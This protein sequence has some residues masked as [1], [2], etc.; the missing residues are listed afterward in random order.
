MTN[1]HI[2]GWGM[3]VPEKVLTNND[4]SKVVDTNDAWIRERTGIRE[5]RIA[6]EGQYPSTLGAEA[7]LKALEMA[8]LSPRQLDLII[9]ATST[10]EHIFPATA[11][12]IQDAI[13]AD[14][15]G[16]FDLLAAC[17]GFIF[18]VNMATQAIRS[19]AIKSAL[20]IGTE[21]LSRFVNWKDRNTCILFGD[22]SGAFVLQASEEPGGVTLGSDAL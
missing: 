19:G 5:R 6:R 20:V 14:N 15:A 13:G 3:S 12:L 18:A 17:S 1:A 10:P 22:G 4:L 9:C 7:S 21:T 2:T 16:A 8:G 11:C